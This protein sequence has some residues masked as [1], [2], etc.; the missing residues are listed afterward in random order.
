MSSNTTRLREAT[1][2]ASSD[3]LTEFAVRVL[4][5]VAAELG[6]ST[7]DAREHRDQ[8]RRDPRWKVGAR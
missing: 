4:R 5:E 7:P 6:V 8:R 2:T 3:D 1:D